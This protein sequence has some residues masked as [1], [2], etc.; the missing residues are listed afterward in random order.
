MVGACMLAPLSSALAQPACPDVLT[1]EG[2]PE[3][4]DAIDAQLQSGLLRNVPAAECANT[5][6]RLEAVG[7]RVRFVVQR[8]AATDEHVTDD[9]STVG[10][11]IESWLLPVSTFQVEPEQVETEQV[12]T[13]Q[14]ENPTLI[15]TANTSEGAES[16]LDTEAALTIVDE[17]ERPPAHEDAFVANPWRMGVRLDVLATFDADRTAP[18][19]WG[20]EASLGL[21]VR[22]KLWFALAAAAHASPKVNGETRRAF[23][24]VLRS[25]WMSR[26][27]TTEVRLGLG[28]GVSYAHAERETLVSGE[29]VESSDDATLPLVELFW[30]I[31][32]ALT[33]SI[34]LVVGVLVRG[35]IPDGLNDRESDGDDGPGE[36]LEPFP[37]ARGSL[38]LRV[39]LSWGRP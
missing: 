16:E 22:P 7:D 10:A 29:E 14:V 26:S 27:D 21:E 18:L 23:R 37:D 12:E 31:R 6:I 8:D 19:W 39:G 15:S 17:D 34:G 28:F 38:S 30:D 9:I 32:Y 3:W 11:W 35:N 20:G 25:G 5:T 24:A 36:Q 33:D 1:Y 2:S 4:V 13:E